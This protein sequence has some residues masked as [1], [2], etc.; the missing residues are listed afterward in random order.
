MLP[1]TKL[2]IFE[3]LTFLI[4]APKFWAVKFL[5]L[6]VTEHWTRLQ[7]GAVES[8]SLEIFKTRLDAVLCSLLWVTLLRL[9]VGPDDPQRCFPTA[10]ILWFCNLRRKDL[11]CLVRKLHAMQK[12]FIFLTVNLEY[13]SIL[14]AIICYE[15]SHKSYP[16]NNMTQ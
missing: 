10:V 8:P 9:G 5:T 12:T 13:V 16:E 4:W 15:W 11:R 14:V 7:K 3:Q 6:R 1:L 2:Q